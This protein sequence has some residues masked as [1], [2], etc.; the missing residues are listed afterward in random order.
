MTLYRAKCVRCGEVHQYYGGDGD[1][2]TLGVIGLNCFC[3][4]GKFRLLG[5]AMMVEAEI[6]G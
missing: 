3:G 6:D 5:E 4:A 2:R 1:M